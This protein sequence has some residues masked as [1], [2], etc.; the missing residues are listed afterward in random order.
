MKE[1]PVRQLARNPPPP[2][3][4][5]DAGQPPCGF[6]VVA[7]TREIGIVSINKPLPAQIVHLLHKKGGMNRNGYGI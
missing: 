7:V 4:A 3:A 1:N 2:R 6:E 5:F